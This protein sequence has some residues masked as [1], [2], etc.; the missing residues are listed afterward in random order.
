MSVILKDN[1]MIEGL[2]DKKS[3]AKK[4]TKKQGDF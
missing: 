1:G 2:I 3:N 4:K